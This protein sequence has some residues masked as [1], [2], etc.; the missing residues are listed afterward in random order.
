MA[1]ARP[2]LSTS[3]LTFWHGNPSGLYGQTLPRI[4]ID[5]IDDE[6]SILDD[7]EVGHIGVKIATP[8]RLAYFVDTGTPGDG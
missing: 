5:V 4:N 1:T 6:G 7:D 8:I 2:K 3:L